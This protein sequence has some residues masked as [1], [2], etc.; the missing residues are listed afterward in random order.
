MG[1]WVC[2]R[3]RWQSETTLWALI[4]LWGAGKEWSETTLRAL[5]EG[6][7][8]GGVESDEKLEWSCWGEPERRSKLF[9]RLQTFNCPERGE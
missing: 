9:K 6:G 2:D 3:G 8:V 1:G 4:E 7:G 5:I